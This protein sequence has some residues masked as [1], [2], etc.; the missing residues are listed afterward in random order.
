MI[1]FVLL[2]IFIIIVVKKEN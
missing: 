2:T 1:V